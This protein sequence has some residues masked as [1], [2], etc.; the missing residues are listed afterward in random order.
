MRLMDR[1]E[2]VPRSMAKKGKQE[3]CTLLQRK[4]K[5][6]IER[7]D[8]EGKLGKVEFVVISYYTHT[9]H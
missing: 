6:E 4:R 8:R 5:R 2:L 7:R 1:I 3:S 9:Y